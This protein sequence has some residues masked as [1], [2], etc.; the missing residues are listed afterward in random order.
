MTPFLPA[1]LEIRF[2]VIFIQLDTGLLVTDVNECSV[3]H[4]CN[5]KIS[6]CMNTNGSYLCKC[7]EGYTQ[8]SSVECIGKLYPPP[9]KKKP[10]GHGKAARS[11]HYVTDVF[12]FQLKNS[13]WC[14]STVC[15]SKVQD[16]FS[17][18]SLCHGLRISD[19]FAFCAYLRRFYFALAIA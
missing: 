18:F 15:N 1:D 11:Y 6:S 2:T 12:R 10:G 8:N 17:L 14:F 9:P 5:M 13:P 19:F 7:V 16:H 3:P 4:S